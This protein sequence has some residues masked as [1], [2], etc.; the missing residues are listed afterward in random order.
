VGPEAAPNQLLELT[1]RA[2]GH[3]EGF[4]ASSAA[5]SSARSFAGL[6]SPVAEALWNGH[7]ARIASERN[8]R[9]SF[10]EFL[11]S[12]ILVS[13]DFFIAVWRISPASGQ[14]EELDRFAKLVLKH[15]VLADACLH[16]DEFVFDGSLFASA[17]FALGN[18][19]EMDVRWQELCN[20]VPIL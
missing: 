1:G 6:V 7:T 4:C 11:Q 8:D 19:V 20:C 16:T 10:P 9:V 3:R 5:C 18:S 13:E 17:E 15:P 14:M 12:A 2:S